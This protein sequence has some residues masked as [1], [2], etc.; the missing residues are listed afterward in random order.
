MK[1]QEV[2]LG[3]LL[4][5]SPISNV[6]IGGLMVVDGRGLPVEF[7]YTEPIQPTK[8]QQV[9]YGSVLSRYI[10]TE[11]ILETLLKSLESKPH[12]LLVNDESFLL[13]DLANK[14]FEVVRLTET[15][16]GP[17]KGLGTVEKISAWEFLLQL[18]P[19][20]SPVRVQLNGGLPDTGDVVGGP[21]SLPDKSTEPDIDFQN[22]KAYTLLFDAG[23]MMDVME[24]L[25][26]VEKALTVLC[27]EA[28]IKAAAG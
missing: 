16:S 10:K 27:Q 5:A 7:R 28:G 12:L 18:T 17:L 21:R 26:R 1:P 11:V 3:Y 6:Y 25:K 8:I 24:P 13:Q 23:R 4:V 19:E 20:S 14:D 9:L 15:K 22:T 2:R